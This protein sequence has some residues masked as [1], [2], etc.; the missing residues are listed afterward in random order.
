[1]AMVRLLPESQYF[2]PYTTTI[3]AL[4]AIA[5][6]DIRAVV[7]RDEYRVSELQLGLGMRL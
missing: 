3:S 1:M 4:A 2:L 6:R 5:R 7:E